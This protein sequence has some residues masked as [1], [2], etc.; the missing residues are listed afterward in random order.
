MR[1]ILTIKRIIVVII[2]AVWSGIT[3]WLGWSY[4]QSQTNIAK[5]DAKIIVDKLRTLMEVPPEE[6]LVATIID[7]EKLKE[8]EPFYKNA[9]NGDK[10]VIWKEKAVIYRMEQNKIIDFGVVIRQ[11]QA[12]EQNTQDNTATPTGETETIESSPSPT[13]AR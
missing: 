11:P 9:Q 4:Y 7:A 13:T 10:V 2:L 6:P 8:N 3:A 12:T 5:N 1:H